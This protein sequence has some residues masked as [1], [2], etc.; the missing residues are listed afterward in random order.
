MAS[1]GRILIMPKGNYDASVTYKMLDMVFHNGTSWLA[2]K[3][4]VGIEPSETNSEYWHKFIELGEVLSNYLHLDGGNLRG[5]LGLGGGAGIITATPDMALIQA[6][7]DNNTYRDIIV[8]NPSK[9]TASNEWLQ[10]GNFVGGTYTTYNIFG[11]HN[12]DLLNAYIDARIN[13]K[14]S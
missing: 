14:M 5:Q 13:A 8:Q 6:K 10:L 3:T 9:N 11:E 12:L 2:K 7:Q 4:A 1:A